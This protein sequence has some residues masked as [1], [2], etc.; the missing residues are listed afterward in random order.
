M[1]SKTKSVEKRAVKKKNASSVRRAPAAR[2]ARAPKVVAKPTPVAKASPK[3]RSSAHERSEVEILMTLIEVVGRA[4]S[5]RDAIAQCL[6][7][8]REGF[9]FEYA[10]FWKIDHEAQALKF[11]QES[12][13]VSEDFRRVT[14]DA[15]FK[16]GEGL[17]GRAWKERDLVYTENLAEVRDCA[18]APSARAAGVRSGV[19]FPLLVEGEII[20]TMDFFTTRSVSFGAE[21][22]AFWRSIGRFVSS[23]IQRFSLAERSEQTAADAQA[24]NRVIDQLGKASS[25]EDLIRLALDAVKDTFG[26]SYAS[27]WAIE[28]VSKTLR[29]KA[30]SGSVSEEFRRVTQSAAF[31]EGEGLNGRAWR[32]RALVFVRDLSEVPDCVRA[33]AARRSGVASGVCIPVLVDGQITGTMDFF[34]MERIALSASR[35][36]ALEK[37]A[38]IVGASLM[39]VAGEERA[40]RHTIEQEH[41]AEAAAKTMR[42]M[43]KLIEAVEQGKLRERIDL[44]GFEGTHLE[45]CQGVNRMMDGIAEP[46]DEITRVLDLVAQGDLRQSVV[47]EYHN[48]LDTLKQSLNGTIEQLS[49]IAVEI[50]GIS[51]HVAHAS[52]EISSGTSDLSKRTEQQ[53]A[54]L[55]ETASTMEEMTAT[56]KQNA[57]NARQANQL[58]MTARSVA[59]KG[60]DVVRQA[61]AGMDEINKSSAKISDIISVIDAIAFQTN[62]LALN[63]AVEAARAGEQGR[64]FAVVASEVRNL[65]QR[66]ATAAKEIKG[67]IK[68]SSSKVE[69]GSKLV[70]QSGNTLNEIVSSVKK[71]ADI[72]GEISAASQEQSSAIEQV[73]NA[74]TR[75]DEFTQQNSALVEQTASAASS[76]ASQGSELLSA[77][78]I[79]KV[80]EEGRDAHAPEPVKKHVESAPARKAAAPT[81]PLSSARRPRPATATSTPAATSAR[82]PPAPAARPNGNHKVSQDEDGFL[83]F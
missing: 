8:V 36:N 23:S 81:A 44:A 20:G 51:G 74:I 15:Q 18:R 28:P 53:A 71:V 70:Q 69:D 60:G 13:S 39:R 42:S 9:G 38:E 40:R 3:S 5:S 48:D 17:N 83:E 21:Q 14:I 49:R 63:A 61:I 73:N 65:A 64:G 79:F 67:L 62:L 47:G 33:P 78:S 43:L 37:A 72:V 59:E 55:E 54:S 26:W 80:D 77:V 29:F 35:R 30:E 19:V 11:Q 27:Y 31:R 1:S 10:S 41:A 46:L 22:L 25:P 4:T 66:S 68:D 32:D 50:R 34:T 56:V 75:M 82:R 76:M 57:E 16:L 24:I 6:A 7:T 12:G 52:E 58:A 2:I 45:L